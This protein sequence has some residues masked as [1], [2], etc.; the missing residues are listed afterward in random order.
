MKKR[1][2]ASNVVRDDKRCEKQHSSICSSQHACSKPFKTLTSSAKK[3]NKT[4]ISATSLH[5]TESGQQAS[6]RRGKNS[7]SHLIT[8]HVERKACM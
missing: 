2:K 1:K 4:N 6:D 3:H 5:S 7:A 8:V